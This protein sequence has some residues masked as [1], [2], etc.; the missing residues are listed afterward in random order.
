MSSPGIPAQLV[1][2]TGIPDLDRYDLFQMF[3]SERDTEAHLGL[4]LWAK[5]SSNREEIVR[6]INMA[7]EGKL[8]PPGYIDIVFNS[9]I[10]RG[11][12]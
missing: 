9:D 12:R 10:A 11:I 3:N 2:V 5:T 8:P 6:E 7:M 4:N 1:C